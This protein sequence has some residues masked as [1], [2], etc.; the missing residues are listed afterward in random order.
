MLGI[1]IDLA[2]CKV[3]KISRLEGEIGGFPNSIKSRNKESEF[4]F[5]F[6][7]N[8]ETS[9]K[10]QFKQLANQ[11]CINWIGCTISQSEFM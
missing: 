10:I 8:K 2:C 4:M 9:K 1:N 6:K 7:L 3:Q 5:D 11:T